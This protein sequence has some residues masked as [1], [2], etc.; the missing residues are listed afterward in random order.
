MLKRSKQKEV[1]LRILRSTPSHPTA[2]WIYIRARKVMPHISLGTVYRNLRLLRDRG[3]IVELDFNG[4]ASRFD[5]DV[6][7][8]YHFSCEECDQVFNVDGAV[9]KGLSKRVARKTGFKISRYQLEFYGLCSECQ[10]VKKQKEVSVDA[11]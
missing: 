4:N 1:I 5:S 11:K 2:D 10:E 6:S 9:D 8:H 3:E 7:D